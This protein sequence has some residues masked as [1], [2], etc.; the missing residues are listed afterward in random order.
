MTGELDPIRVGSDPSDLAVGL[1]AAWVSDQSEG[2]IYRVDADATTLAT[3][4]EV[5]AP[6]AAVAVDEEANTLWLVTGR[7]P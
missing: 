7:R 3:P 2:V 5:G 6:V 4:I 1:G